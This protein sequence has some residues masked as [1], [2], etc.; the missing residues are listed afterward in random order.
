MPIVLAGLI[1]AVIVMLLFGGT[2][3]DRGLLMLLHASAMPRLSQ[4]AQLVTAIASPLAL[5]LAAGAGAGF[6]LIRTGWQRALLLVAAAVGAQLLTLLI[7]E[8]TMA[9]RPLSSDHVFPTQGTAFPDGT[10]SNAAATGIA[11]AILL[12]RRVPWRGIAL[13]AA[14]AFALAAGAGRI[15]LGVAW[16]SDVIGGWGVGLFWTLLLLWLAGEDLGDGTPRPVRHSPPKGELHGRE[17][18]GRDRP[19]ER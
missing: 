17:S 19:P 8:A 7:A 11:L 10:A 9:L 3:L 2:E 14:T 5:M 13:F 12:T 16:P 1:L 6:L 4:A 15:M 18:Q